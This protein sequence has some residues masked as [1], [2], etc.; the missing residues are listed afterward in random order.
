[1]I[2]AAKDVNTWILS[3]QY[4]CCFGVELTVNNAA[5]LYFQE[6]FGQSTESAA[7]IAGAFGLMNLFARGAGGFVSDVSNAAL[8]MRG[9]LMW[10]SICLLCEGL[11]IILFANMNTLTSAIFLM[12][13]FSI[14]VQASEGSTFGIVPYVN[15]PVTGSIAGAVL[16]G[17]IFR[18]Y[19]YNTSF[20][21]MGVIAAFSSIV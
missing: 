16:F 20:T 14:F 3:V 19:D 5:A 8:G 1:M 4:A 18:T 13:I 2:L 6:E 10:Q 9:R 12:T 17:M 11:L 7:A 15:P 21:Y